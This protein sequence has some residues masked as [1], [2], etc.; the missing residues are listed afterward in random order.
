MH[1]PPGGQLEDSGYVSAGSGSAGGPKYRNPPPPYTHVLPNKQVLYNDH[2][3]IMTHVGG[4]QGQSNTTSPMSS[5]SPSPA[6]TPQSHSPMVQGQNAHK[7]PVAVQAWNAKQPPI[8][9][10]QVKSREVPKPVLQTATAPISPPP[11]SALPP[12]QQQAHP[13]E[14][15]NEHYLPQHSYI[16]EVSTRVNQ[17]HLHNSTNEHQLYPQMQQQQQVQQPQRLPQNI[18]SVQIRKGSIE[19]IQSNT[20]PYQQSSSMQPH[21][22]GGSGTININIATN[23]STGHIQVQPGYG[24]TH[25]STQEQ[26]VPPLHPMMDM[27]RYPQQMDTPSST[28]RSHSPEAS[29]VITISLLYL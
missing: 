5:H 9:L 11:G 14:Q 28:L 4:Q 13:S 20:Q 8:F 19:H 12:Q 15:Y 25:Y 29:R 27:S 1:P 26:R 24:V 10:Q 6:P 18:H 7:Q 16:T 21:P 3:S 23:G 17:P 2:N 22:P